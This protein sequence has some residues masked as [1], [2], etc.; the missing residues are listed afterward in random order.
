MESR[1]GK[2]VITIETIQRTTIRKRKAAETVRCDRCAAEIPIN[3]PAAHF[4]LDERSGERL[5]LIPGDRRTN[6]E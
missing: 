6:G 3:P 5:E 4:T 1:N 2:T